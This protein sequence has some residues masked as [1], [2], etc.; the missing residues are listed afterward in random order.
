M[1][2]FK[3]I[4]CLPKRKEKKNHRNA[5]KQANKHQKTKSSKNVLSDCETWNESQLNKNYINQIIKVRI[6][7]LWT[8]RNLLSRKS[9]S[10]C[11]TRDKHVCLWYTIPRAKVSFHSSLGLRCKE[12]LPLVNISPK[13]IIFQLIPQVWGSKH[14]MYIDKIW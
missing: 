2:H 3:P 10:W 8:C 13:I 11:P 9:L 4:L 12:Q 5:V 1:P 6:L 7:V 14:S